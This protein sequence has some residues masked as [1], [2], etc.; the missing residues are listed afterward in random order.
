MDSN[1]LI[2]RE[3]NFIDELCTKH[4]YHMNIRHLLY[5][6]IPAFIIR[7]GIDNEIMILNTFKRVKIIP[8]KEKDNT[9]YAFYTSIPYHIN[10][11]LEIQEFIIINN[12]NNNSLPAFVDSLVHE[13]NHA[14]NS[15]HK[16]YKIDND[17][18]YLRTGLTYSSFEFP[19][20]K[21]ITK[22]TSYV[23]EEILNTKQTEEIINII[24]KMD[25]ENISI[26]NA[27]YS[28]NN[29]TTTEYKSQAYLLES[30]ICQQILDNKTF[31][32]TL[33]NLR[34]RGDIEDIEP[35]FDNICGKDGSYQL[36]ITYLNKIMDLEIKLTQTKL[37]KK[38]LIF[39]IRKIMFKITKL[40]SL[41]DS[42][43]LF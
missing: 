40:I 3:K 32:T 7:Y 42:Q 33:S 29:E 22:D 31:V 23:L 28:I 9:N 10:N 35:W 16:K 4:N 26:G 12:F 34:L 15:Y 41:F 1:K 20:L 37:F 13:F 2:E 38:A 43:T 21:Y 8:N 39:R 5:F 30:Y 27:I 19:S 18:L 17:Y 24:K 14:I 11:K 25:V 6:V 36:F